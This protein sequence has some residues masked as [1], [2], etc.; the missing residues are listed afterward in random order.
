MIEYVLC[1]DLWFLRCLFICDSILSVLLCFYSKI[2]RV[3]VYVKKLVFFTLFIGV[4][5]L[6]LYLKNLDFFFNCYY[7]LLFLF[8]GL[9]LNSERGNMLLS[10]PE[11]LGISVVCFCLLEHYYTSSGTSILI[12]YP[13]AL[14][15]SFSLLMICKNFYKSNRICASLIGLGKVTLPIYCMHLLFLKNVNVVFFEWNFLNLITLIAIAILLVIVCFIICEVFSICK[16]TDFIF[17]GNVKSIKKL[18]L[19]TI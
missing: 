18:T 1:K 10:T 17:N 3:N 16:Y 9:L 15:G 12:R 6:L 5:I 19:I 8:V 14:F 7:Y 11:C 13:L 4:V 2:G